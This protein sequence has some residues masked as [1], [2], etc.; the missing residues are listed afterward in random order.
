MPNPFV[1]ETK[2]CSPNVAGNVL[3][4]PRVSETLSKVFDY[5]L[6]LLQAGAG[7]GKTTVLALLA[8]ETPH[9][10]WYQVSEEDQDP[11]V[12]LLH[13]CYATLRVYPDLEGLPIP[14]LETWEPSRGPLMYREVISQYLN[15]FGFG[16]HTPTLVVLD[17]LHL[18][19]EV[20]E[21]AYLLDRLIGLAPGILHFVIS[22]RQALQ[23]PNLFRWRSMGQVLFLDQSVL[24]FSQGEIADLFLTLYKVELT[25]EEVEDL[26]AAT[27]GWAISLQ[28]IGQSLT[29][30]SS[31]SVQH[32][33]SRR[34]SP[35]DSLF[36]VLAADVLEGQT[37]E[38][39]SF[40]CATSV[41]R[42]M[43]SGVCNWLLSIDD[44][45][46]KLACLTQN[47]LFVSH[48]K[49]DELLYH[50]IFQQ[51]LYRQISDERREELHKHAAL[52]YLKN[53]DPNSAIYHYLRAEDYF[54]AAEVLDSYGGT[55]HAMGHLDTLANYL[56]H[57]SPEALRSYPNLIFYMGD[58]ARLHSRFE[59]AL[60][61]YQQAEALWRERGQ[62]DGIS[63]ALRGQARIYLD[64]VNPRKAE[65]L[66]QEALRL[67]DGLN[68]R[69][70][71]ARLYQLLAENKL[72]AGKVDEAEALRQQAETLRQEGPD[73]TQLEYRVLLRTGRLAEARRQ[74]ELQA[75]E[76]N[77]EPISMPRSHRETQLL[78]SIICAMMGDAQ[79]AMLS[80]EKG[81]LRGKELTSP[82]VTAV[83]Y[84]RQGH[85][86][87]L[88]PDM[89]GYLQAG[90][91]FEQ[92]VEISEALSTP[93]LRVEAL[94]GLARVHGYQGNLEESR[95][96]AD[97]GIEIATQAGDEWI[98]SLSRLAIGASY[99]LGGQYVQSGEW[100][101]KALRGFQ[102]C[103]DPFGVSATRMWQCLGWY[104]QGEFEIL[105]QA[106]L[107]LLP[108]CQQNE[109][110]FLFTK[111]TML[112]PPD[113]RL[114]LPMLIWARDNSMISRSNI[115][116]LLAEFGLED[117]RFHPGYQLRVK[118]LGDF[119]VWRGRE[120][121]SHNE[122]R[123]E[124]TRQLF[125]VLVT[126]RHAPLD[127]EQICEFL[128]PGTDP[129]SA[130]R[131]F[132]V[133]L[134]A[135]YG[136]LEPDRNPGQESAYVLREGTVYGLRPG[137]DVK[138]DAEIFLEKLSLA[139]QITSDEMGRA[140]S[141]FEEAFSLYTGEY[142]PDAR[143]AEWSAIE[144][145][146]LAVHYLQSADRYCELNLVKKEYQKVIEECQR[147]L[148]QDSCWE[149]AYRHLMIAFDGLGDHGQMARTYQRCMETL[150]TELN[151]MPSS[152][153][154]ALYHRL[155][156]T[157]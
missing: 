18:V 1:L 111:I 73:D 22:T 67:S 20:P 31:R 9:V 60:G 46:D 6:T 86:Y 49:Q 156:S 95:R 87:M 155:S 134:N 136:V 59:E 4:R 149:R 139:D 116:R 3:S 56:D 84:M 102:E 113:E 52:F 107:D 79:E 103:S 131:N 54:S 24:T 62:I 7:Y 146:H 148:A 151:V 8:K 104:Q 117:I 58:L 65:E 17:D 76:E 25:E 89:E 19:A 91:L 94:W 85:A 69:E 80:S 13:L 141:L 138:I 10:V 63:R 98:A 70:T 38:M 109:Y 128:W 108:V 152:E 118:T 72:N 34:E 33:L 27:E 129:E 23:L 78:L 5:R 88:L 40:M 120:Q 29:S 39:Q 83:G 143:Y 135:L 125:Q 74:L 121:I 127:R 15:A 137:C 93:R 106:L 35:L 119:L 124:K 115:D 144:R 82:F 147:I 71:R 130:Q 100:L 142:L 41:L 43:S 110:D 57:L 150:K 126:Y 153:T 122:W 81:I 132:K 48:L 64:T 92:V 112:G 68:D 45:G 11:F 53:Q 96:L 97:R 157:A 50:P 16:V 61:W 55:L 133:A 42:T 36:E 75:R 12:F 140:I 14:L 47:D 77:A 154:E 123:R 21:I 30:G 99:I 66:L 145:E 90:K 28:L 26:Y 101:D 114:L 37:Q 32:A 2:I 105:T 44:S 51:F